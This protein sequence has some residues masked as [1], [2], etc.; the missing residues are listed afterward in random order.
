[1]IFVPSIGGRSHTPEEW[2][3]PEDMAKGVSVLTETLK[4]L[5]Y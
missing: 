1:M 5:A 4:R 2:T 3:S